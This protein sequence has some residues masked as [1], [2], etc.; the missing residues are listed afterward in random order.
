MADHLTSD[1][2]S[3]DTEDGPYQFL[4]VIFDIIISLIK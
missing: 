3:V 4:I 2:F 1:R